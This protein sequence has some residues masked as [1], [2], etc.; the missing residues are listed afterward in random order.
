M[1]TANNPRSRIEL[2]I[3]I[4]VQYITS[5]MVNPEYATYVLSMCFKTVMFR[6]VL[7]PRA[8]TQ[9]KSAIDAGRSCI[10]ET[11]GISLAF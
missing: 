5:N 9:F 3:T 7:I 2:K 10:P 6:D 11:I 1:F 4:C 8:P